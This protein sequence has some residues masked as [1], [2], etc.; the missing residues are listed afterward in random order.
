MHIAH[1]TRSR[2]SLEMTSV[3]SQSCTGSGRGSSQFPWTKK[4]GGLRGDELGDE[5]MIDLDADLEADDA[6]RPSSRA[7]R[8]SN[9]RLRFPPRQVGLEAYSGEIDDSIKD[10]H[11]QHDLKKHPLAQE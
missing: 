11:L 1:H 8:R 4:G 5:L 9:C 3:S 7:L 2:F 6:V 10:T